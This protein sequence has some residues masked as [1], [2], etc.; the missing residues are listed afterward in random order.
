VK[1]DQD[2]LQLQ[3]ALQAATEEADASDRRFA[4]S[5]FRRRWARRRA[6]QR[7]VTVL[8]VVGVLLAI[9]TWAMLRID[10]PSDAEL[11]GGREVVLQLAAQWTHDY[12]RLHGAPPGAI[13]A[14]LPAAQGVKMEPTPDG[15]RL[16]ITDDD[17]KRH[18]VTVPV[19]HR[20]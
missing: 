3:Q 7:Y 14:D 12:V 15:V 5:H 9:G 19:P 1:Q 11:D 10:G 8:S 6:H 13:A 4:N 2:D 18:E 20:R 16:S 17:G